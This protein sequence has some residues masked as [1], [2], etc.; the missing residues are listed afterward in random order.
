M[1][2]N[3]QDWGLLVLRVGVGLITFY[4]GTQKLLGAF[5]G[6]G[7]GG[8]LHFMGG[9]GIPSF[10]A[11]LAIVAEFFGSLGLILGLLTRYAAFGIF[12]TV[13]TAAY[14]NSQ[15][16]TFAKIFSTSSGMAAAEVFYPLALAFAA[17]SLVIS[18]PGGLSL[19][20]MVFKSKGKGRGK[21]G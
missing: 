1:K 5:G 16:G 4:Y 19:D 11:V 21:K 14:F 17:L 2:F 13:A 3:P 8:T 6:P 9:M 10:L 15:H 18:G 7:F 12:C 20:A